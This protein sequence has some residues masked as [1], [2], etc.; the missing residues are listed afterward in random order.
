MQ[1]GDWI[2]PAA[3]LDRLPGAYAHPGYDTDPT[4]VF[5]SNRVDLARGFASFM[6]MPDGGTVYRVE[7][8]GPLAEDPDYAGDSVSWTAARARIVEIVEHHPVM[9]VRE[10]VRTNGPFQKWKDST[11]VYDTDGFLVRSPEMRA[12]NVRADQ[13]RQLG[14]WIP[15]EVAARA[16]AECGPLGWARA[17]ALA[18]RLIR[19]QDRDADSRRRRSARCPV[20]PIEA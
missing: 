1:V 8:D 4:C 16:A 10:H 17:A 2:V 3:S 7:P 9:S 20:P 19:Q 13:L 15:W 11:P 18:E 12:L 5:M 6:T 14:Q